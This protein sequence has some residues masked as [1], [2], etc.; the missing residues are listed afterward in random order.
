MKLV[1]RFNKVSLADDMSIKSLLLSAE[2][3]IEYLKKINPG[4]VMRFG[5]REVVPAELIESHRRLAAIFKEE[6]DPE[7]RS[8]R[9]RSEFDIF[10][11]TGTTDGGNVLIT[12]YFQPLIK[13]RR[14]QDEIY[15]W[16]IYRRPD[17]L[18][19]VDLGLFSGELKGKR[20]TGRVEKGRM[21]PY[22]DRRAIDR[23][24]A[25][26]KRG[27]EVAWVKDRVDLF[28][29]SV[30]GSG[31]VEYRDGTRE[32]IN[33]SAANGRVYR[34]IGKLL[35]NEMA[36]S[37]EAMSLKAIRQWLDAHPDQLERVLDHNPSYVFF[38]VMDDGPFGSTGAKLV[39][40]RSA[41]FDPSKFP[42]GA[43][44]H[45]S[46]VFPGAGKVG[47][48]VSNHDQGGAIKGAGRMD[49]FFGLGE[50]AEESAGE[51][52]HPGELLLLVLKRKVYLRIVDKSS[53]GRTSR[54]GSTPDD[55]KTK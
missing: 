53:Q 14:Q 33:Y 24:G 17:D 23:E 50:R 9:I 1:N 21:V 41:A 49:L 8:R 10:R 46:S 5:G 22:Y 52:K 34:S 25:L 43:L 16:P 4:K 20:I 39:P 30:Q 44:A 27:L 19:R 40:G 11:G 45:F 31:V 3:S 29:L 38:R 28:F 12:G 6:K 7:E 37:K 36:V 35:I 48:F 47:R 13:A 26:S 18:V 42:K 51:L 32:F 54:G 55:N 2:E 15:K